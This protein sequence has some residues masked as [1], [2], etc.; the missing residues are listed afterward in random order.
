MVAVKQGGAQGHVGVEVQGAGGGVRRRQWRLGRRT[1]K[2]RR[3]GVQIGFYRGAS[4]VDGRETERGDLGTC[5]ACAKAAAAC[6]VW[7]FWACAI[8]GSKKGKNAKEKGREGGA[9]T[10][11]PACSEREK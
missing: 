6:R 3:E 11:G 4:A 2:G 7:P 10:C 8:D 5:L 9:L 1:E